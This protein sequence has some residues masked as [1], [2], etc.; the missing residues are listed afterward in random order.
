MAK[1][2]IESESHS[3]QVGPYLIGVDMS[4]GKD[5]TVFSIV[6]LVPGGK[7]KLIGQFVDKEPV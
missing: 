7:H 6:K 1:G 5:H 4:V 2:V 3:I